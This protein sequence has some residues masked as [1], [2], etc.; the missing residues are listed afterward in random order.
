MKNHN[1]VKVLSLVFKCSASRI[2]TEIDLARGCVGSGARNETVGSPTKKY[3]NG[4]KL[5]EA[6]PKAKL[7]QWRNLRFESRERA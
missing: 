1:Q 3:T 4:A 6:F 7:S 5:N 2:E